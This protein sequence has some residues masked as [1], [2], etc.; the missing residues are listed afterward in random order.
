MADANNDGIPDVC[1][2]PALY[3]KFCFCPAPMGPCGNDDPNAGCKNSTGVGAQLTP[4]G[5]TSV[6]ADDL[7]LTATALP[8][9]KQLILMMSAGVVA[10]LPFSDGRRCLV[11]L[12]S[13]F[14]PKNSGAGGTAAYGPGL[15]AYSVGA[16]PV[17]NHI[18]PGALFGFQAWYRDP[19]GP[20]GSGSNLTNAVRATFV[21]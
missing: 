6:A 4:S 5:S 16:F 1:S 13:R 18:V 21:P 9:N 11:G 14:P 7:V 3:G 20:C 10:P 19:T 17:L 8:T 15:A 12:I 2:P